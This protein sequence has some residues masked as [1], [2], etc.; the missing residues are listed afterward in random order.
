MSKPLRTPAAEPPRVGDALARL[1]EQHGLSLDE[2]SRRAGVSKSM[3]SQIERAQANPTVAVVWRLANALGVPLGSLLE[4]APAAPEPAITT[5]AS[6]ATPTLRGADAG[7]EL[8]ILG[9]IELAGQFEW[10][11][12]TLQA[13]ASLVSQAHEPGSFEHVSVQ[14]GHIQVSAGDATAAL[15]PGETARYAADQPHALR[16]KGRSVATAILVVLHKA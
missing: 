16:N 10:Y 15:G 7:C 6:H 12:L 2:L 8:R 11:E 1:R 3:L 13:G 9:P 5:V 4:Q 14:A